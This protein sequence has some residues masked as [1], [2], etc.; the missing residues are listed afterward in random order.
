[1]AQMRVRGVAV[2]AR[3]RCR[4][5][6]RGEK[7]SAVADAHVSITGRLAG[8]AA[9]VAVAQY[10]LLP[11]CPLAALID[12]LMRDWLT[13]PV[14]DALSKRKRGSEYGVESTLGV[15]SFGTVYKASKDI[16]VKVAR[17]GQQAA[18]LQN[19]EEVVCRRVRRSPR[20]RRAV[21]D[22]L[23]VFPGTSGSAI[24]ARKPNVLAWR[25]NGDAT[26]EDMLQSENFLECAE[27]LVFKGNVTGSY[28]RQRKAVKTLMRQVA[29]A[30][31]SLNA[32]GLVHRDIKPANLVGD[33]SQGRLVLVD[34]G[35]CVDLRTGFNFAPGEGVL[36]PRFGP[37]EASILPESIPPPPP[38]PLAAL[39]SPFIWFRWK[40]YLFDS[41]CIGLVLLQLACPAL[42]RSQSLNKRSTFQ[43]RLRIADYDFESMD[44]SDV[45]DFSLLR[46]QWKLGFDGLDLVSRLVCDKSQRIS[47]RAALA[48]PFLALPP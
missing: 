10:L 48:H 27:D 34:L 18:D 32:A 23:G 46:E 14:L 8:D 5:T 40:P 3:R 44:E 26:L 22:F 41:Y 39:F 29:L 1:M 38:F 30:G 7:L 9:I 12:T 16:V 11:P 19:A 2:R 24:D 47:A 20:A 25:A 33:R 13:E 35:A 37:P 42:R 31:A 45:E 15:G 28:K 36:D 21:P 17:N 4:T 43:T 6:R